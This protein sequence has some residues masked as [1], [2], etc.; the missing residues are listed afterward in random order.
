M[1]VCLNRRVFQNV[2]KSI[3]SKSFCQN[4]E[5]LCIEQSDCPSEGRKNPQGFPFR[6]K[7]GQTNPPKIA[8][9]SP[10]PYFH[11]YQQRK[12][13]KASHIEQKRNTR[14]LLLD[15]IGNILKINEINKRTFYGNSLYRNYFETFSCDVLGTQTL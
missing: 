12:N 11:I 1:I 3:V 13:R 15:Y 9:R 8:N 4:R 5:I 2:N 14:P 10:N 7:I 6:K